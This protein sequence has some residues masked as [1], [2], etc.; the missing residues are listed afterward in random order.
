M[1]LTSAEIQ[2]MAEEV[3]AEALELVEDIEKKNN[4]F[5]RRVPKYEI[6]Y[7]I[8]TIRHLSATVLSLSQTSASQERLVEIKDEEIDVLQRENLNLILHNN[9]LSAKLAQN[10]ESATKNN[11]KD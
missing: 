4:S 9:H 5:F 7:I 2:D 10:T 11:E 1:A 6:T 8:T 3:I